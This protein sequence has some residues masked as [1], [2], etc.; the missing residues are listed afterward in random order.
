MESNLS[1][2]FGRWWLS[3][4]SE[5]SMKAWSR[6]WKYPICQQGLPRSLVT[7]E[8]LLYLLEFYRL[9][10]FLSVVIW[11]QDLRILIWGSKTITRLLGKSGMEIKVLNLFLS[12]IISFLL[13]TW[14]SGS[15]I[16]LKM[17]NSWARPKSMKRSRNK[18][19]LEKQS[20]KTNYLPTSSNRK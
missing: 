16:C 4:W 17:W 10:I 15:T 19:N 13:E 11:Q 14:I 8:L 18:T 5:K 12:S 20:Q 6:M 7:K 3:S 2:R 1:F 9:L